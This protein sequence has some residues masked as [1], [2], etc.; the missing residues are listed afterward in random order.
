MSATISEASHSASGATDYKLMVQLPPLP[1]RGMLTM[2]NCTL[3][4]SG[5]RSS[6]QA[7][8]AL[9][10][11]RVAGVFARSVSMS[12]PFNGGFRH[13]PPRSG[14]WPSETIVE[15]E[16]VNGA[17]RPSLPPSLHIGPV[18]RRRELSGGRVGCAVLPDGARN[19][20]V[21]RKHLGH[22][23]RGMP[24]A[25]EPHDKWGEAVTAV[26]VAREGARPSAE[27]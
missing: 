23:G 1:V 3:R 2:S 6:A 26:I 9:I 7:T 21:D 13:D 17:L 22:S 4:H 18:A 25:P 24:R 19:E 11:S 27:D 20:I 12:H 10:S 14:E 15:A 16:L 8:R 5:C